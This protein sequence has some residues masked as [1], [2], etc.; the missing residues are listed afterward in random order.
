MPSPVLSQGGPLGSP[1]AR[2]RVQ[3]SVEW[4]VAVFGL[5]EGPELGLCSQ[6]P[7]TRTCCATGL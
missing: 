2:A 3:P 4:G 6:L 1:G 7:W 5:G